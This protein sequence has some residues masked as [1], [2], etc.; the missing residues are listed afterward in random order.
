MWRWCSWL[1]SWVVLSRWVRD[2]ASQGTCLWGGSC[3]WG[4]LSVHLLSPLS[5]S[6]M[7]ADHQLPLFWAPGIQ[8][9]FQHDISVSFGLS[10]ALC[11]LFG[12]DVVS[13]CIFLHKLTCLGS[14]VGLWILPLALSV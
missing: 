10:K 9:L 3:L 2:W 6:D 14:S 4:D 8:F 7:E 13:P 11:S 5:F 1:V 12:L